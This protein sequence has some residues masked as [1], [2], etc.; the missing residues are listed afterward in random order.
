MADDIAAFKAALQK[1]MALADR[2]LDKKLM[3]RKPKPPPVVEEAPEEAEEAD[4]TEGEMTPEE[5]QE[6]AD[7]YGKE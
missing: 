1:V 3:D 4:P 2:A 6:L 5:E 7:L